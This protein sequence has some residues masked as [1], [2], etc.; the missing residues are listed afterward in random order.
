MNEK[1]TPVFEQTRSDDPMR[2]AS[3]VEPLIDSITL[4]VGQSG[5]I[6]Y[7]IT[8]PADANP[9]SHVGAIFVSRE[10]DATAE[11]GA[12]V[13]FS[14][15]SLINLR[16]N[17]DVINELKLL[18]FATDRALYTNS[19]ILFTARIENTGTIY[20]RPLGLITITDMFGKDVA[21]LPFNE[22][23]G[24]IIPGSIRAFESMWSPDGFR[25]GRYTATVS[26]VFGEGKRETK[27]LQ[28]SFWI[29]PIKEVGIGVGSI[30]VFLLVLIV[31]VRAYV[32][33]ELRN[34]GH[35]RSGAKEQT[36]VTFANRL[37]RTLTK[38]VV[39]LI[40]AFVVMVIF[41]Q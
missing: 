11:S 31:G 1:G 40:V 4:G 26:I 6:P 25:M 28:T 34:A 2:L 5:A 18:S 10:A 3:W 33:R 20:Q 37:S 24:G 15:A 14:V 17:G 22:E 21:T 35:V 29:L 39:L 32:K 8:V 30:V 13:G 9:G 19:S 38:L 27:Y 23:E 36:S 7:R 41:F 16:V 12:G